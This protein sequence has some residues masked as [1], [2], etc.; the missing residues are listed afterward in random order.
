MRGPLYGANLLDQTIDQL[1]AGRDVTE[2][3]LVAHAGLVGKIIVGQDGTPGTRFTDDTKSAVF[4]RAALKTA[5]RCPI[6][7]GYLDPEKSVSYDHV[8]AVREGGQG[9]DANCQLTHPYC[10]Q[11]VKQ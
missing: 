7:N 6:C 8:L 10:N 3:D 5:I 11:S 1:N 2:A 9:S 4:I